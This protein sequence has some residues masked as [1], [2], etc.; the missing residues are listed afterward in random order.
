[1]ATATAAGL[2]ERARRGA[3]R[4]AGRLRWYPATVIRGGEAKGLRISLRQASADYTDGTNELPVQ[5]AIVGHLGRGSVFYD[6]GSNVGFFSLLAARQVGEGGRVYAFEP[7]PLNARC[8]G[9][10]AAANSFDNIVVVE[11][12]VGAAIGRHELLV[13]EH[14]GGATLSGRDRPPG[15]TG[16]IEVPVT[17]IDEFVRSG[18]GRPP[19]LVKIDVEGSEIDV[20]RGM[21]ETLSTSRPVVLCELDDDEAAG[22]EEKLE[23]FRRALE[24]HGYAVA[25]LESSYAHAGWHVAHM[26]AVPSH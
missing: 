25:M 18:A 14:P 23:R 7:L 22:L 20:V 6:V 12:A 11:A 10:N 17:T 16:M 21:S 9:A 26:L 19:T 2:V 1:M 8:I 3:R 13:T 24:P 4:V 15:V 5:R